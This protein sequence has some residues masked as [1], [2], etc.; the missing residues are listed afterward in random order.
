MKIW[1]ISDTHQYHDRLI[2]PKNIDLVIHS[3]DSCNKRDPYKNENEMRGFL[4]WFSELDIEYKVFVAGNH[5][6]CLEQGLIKKENMAEMG[7]HYLFMDSV[8]IRGLKIWG[9]PFCPV[10]GNW[11]FMKKR[12]DMMEKVWQFVPSD[13]DIL[14]THTPPKNI[15]DYTYNYST[16]NIDICG[17]K[18][19]QKK[20]R[21]IE[22]L[23]HCFGHIH[24]CKDIENSGT[25]TIKGI[26]TLFSNGA[27]CKD[28]AFGKVLFNG[29]VF[30]LDVESGVVTTLFWG[31]E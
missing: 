22:P 19:L 10:Y 12:E 28:N 13:T 5:D 6:T 26:D 18:S 21:E 27:C 23:L 14:V 9:S 15:L 31:E 17:C 8:E 2:I 20:V 3:G 1:H 4:K 24:N 30:K 29:N 11:A 16:K 7:I 25:K